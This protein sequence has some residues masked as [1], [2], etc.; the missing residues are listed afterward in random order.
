MSDSASPA[1]ARG[2]DPVPMAVAATVLAIYIVLIVTLIRM[3]SDDHWDRLVFLF[4]GF[5]A[6][7]F[8]AAGW[9]FG[10][11]VQRSRVEGAETAR[12]QAVDDAETARAEEKFARQEKDAA[13]RDAERGRALDAAVKAKRAGMESSR[14]GAR[15]GDALSNPELAEL[16]EI[17][18]RLFPD[19][20]K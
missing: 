20:A 1:K 4:A 17:A 9:M 8:A 13:I 12:Q 18:E 15:P 16:L 11:T 5:E 2:I 3:R 14:Q 10:T 6:I 7:V 19:Q